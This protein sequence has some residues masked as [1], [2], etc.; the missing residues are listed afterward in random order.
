[1]RSLAGGPMPSAS[2]STSRGPLGDSAM[3]SS[4]ALQRRV[5]AV[6]PAALLAPGV[7]RLLARASHDD[8]VGGQ[9]A[10]LLVREQLVEGSARDAGEAD[11]VR[12]GRGLV[13]ALGDRLDHAAVE[14]GALVAG[15]LVA[16]HP[17][18]PV[19]QSAIQRCDLA[20]CSTCPH[21]RLPVRPN[22][23]PALEFDLSPSFN[24]VDQN[25]STLQVVST[26]NN[27]TSRTIPAVSPIGATVR[28]TMRFGSP[29]IGRWAWDS[30]NLNGRAR[31]AEG[32]LR[33][34]SEETA[35]QAVSVSRRGPG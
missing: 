22:P 19:R 29:G 17:A 8:V 18:R 4:S 26:F 15:D 2:T 1:M 30:T 35:P 11:H 10:L 33:P 20:S 31:W 32:G 12:D 14:A 6:G 13:A 16:A 3:S 24:K 7:E 28:Q 21:A 23:T 27:K 34:A 25:A 5:Q 9:E